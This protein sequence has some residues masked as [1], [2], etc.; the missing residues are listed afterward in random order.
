MP[1]LV[2]VAT[3]LEE[4]RGP[5]ALPDIGAPIEQTSLS[6]VVRARIDRLARQV[7]TLH[8]SAAR[9]APGARRE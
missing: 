1:V 5:L 6:A 7:N 9:M 8:D 4:G 3:A 2:D